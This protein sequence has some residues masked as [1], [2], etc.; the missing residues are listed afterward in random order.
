MGIVILECEEKLAQLIQEM[1]QEI[2]ARK[3]KTG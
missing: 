2:A 1:K 3:A